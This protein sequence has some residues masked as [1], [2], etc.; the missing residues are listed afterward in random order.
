MF[1]NSIARAMSFLFVVGSF[2]DVEVVAIVGAEFSNCPLPR[3]S[4]YREPFRS[5]S[6]FS[7]GLHRSGR[8]T[9]GGPA[10][11]PSGRVFVLYGDYI[12]QLKLLPLY[13][14]F[15][16]NNKIAN[17]ISIDFAILFRR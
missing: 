2:L 8:C 9:W 4:L 16:F 11:E 15:L 12:L 1:P 5:S 14:V 7:V 17:I 10:C 3:L 6:A 13:L